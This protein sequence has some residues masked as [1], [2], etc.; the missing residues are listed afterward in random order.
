M[1]D[2]LVIMLNALMRSPNMPFTFCSGNWKDAR[3]VEIGFLFAV[4]LFIYNVYFGSGIFAM[5][6]AQMA[7]MQD[8]PGMKDV[9]SSKIKKFFGLTDDQSFQSLFGL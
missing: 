4:F 9:Y 6:F 1:F 7:I 8:T 3:E 5:F 2:Y